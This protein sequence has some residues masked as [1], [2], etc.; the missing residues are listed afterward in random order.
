MRV[1][2][3]ILDMIEHSSNVY[4]TGHKG[5]DLDA[6]GSILAVYSICQSLNKEVHIYL[7]EIEELCVNRSLTGLHRRNFDLN[8]IE[9]Y[10]S[11]NIDKDSLMIIVDVNKKTLIPEYEKI[12][13]LFKN[14][15]IIDHHID[16][17]D[18]IKNLKIKYIDSKASSVCEMLT[19]FIKN[20]N[21]KIESYIA[22]IMLGGI[23]IDTNSF[24]SKTSSK[25]H[26]AASLLYDF[27]ADSQLVNYLMKMDINEYKE[28]NKVIENVKIIK[29]IYAIVI[30]DEHIC[31]KELLSKV[32]EA[33]LSFN[34]IEASFTIGQLEE[35][36]VGVSARSLGYIDVNAKMKLL[37]GGGHK[38]DAATQIKDLSK[39]E[40][41]DE[42]IKVL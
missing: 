16:V 24:I 2:N 12:E 8:Y 33:L 36:V 29:K 38:Y 27:G 7:E 25:T 23:I 22:T 19:Y 32:S 13:E 17:E 1:Y 4:I 42:I 34:E 14:V 18:D 40:V 21:I 26:L 9:E 15:I 10:N 35:D 20:K 31:D 28:I 5:L 6:F 39:E 30:V 37:G 11:D 41:Y 3:R